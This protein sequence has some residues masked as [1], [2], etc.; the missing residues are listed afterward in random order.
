IS[1]GH[2]AGRIMNG[3]LISSWLGLP[4]GSWPPNHYSLLGLGPR[5]ADPAR[6]EQSV[7]ERMDKVRHYQLSFPEEATEAMNRLAQALICLTAPGAK[8][9]YDVELFPEEAAQNELE[10]GAIPRQS[11]DPLAWL[12]APPPPR[13]NTPA[14][15]VGPL[16]P[17]GQPK[18]PGG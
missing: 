5:E 17:S 8:R 16:G 3:D 7:H 15:A 6:V 14:G 10:R 18:E 13:G 9:A 1:H 12:F 4:S 11:A 2:I